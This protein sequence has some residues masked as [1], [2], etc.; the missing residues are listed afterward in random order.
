MEQDF[1]NLALTDRKIDTAATCAKRLE[2]FAR[3]SVLALCSNI[4]RLLTRLGHRDFCARIV[5]SQLL[6]WFLDV[7][8]VD[9][10]KV[11]SKSSSDRFGQ[12][13]S[14]ESL[15]VINQKFNALLAA[16]GADNDSSQ[17]PSA[18]FGLPHTISFDQVFF[19]STCLKA[20]LHFPT[21]WVLLRDAAH[22]LMKATVLI[23]KHGLKNR[24]PQGPLEFLSEMNTLC[25][26]MAAKGR[27][28]NGKK[29]RK[30]VL[31]EMKTLEKCIAFHAQAHL[32][33]LKI[34]RDETEFSEAQAKQIIK[35]MEG[36]L[37]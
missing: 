25:I 7:G 3:Y 33:A 9:S 4:A 22:T 14:A 27:T 16:T 21:E 24:M 34:R 31:C 19:D 18:S 28:V 36:V 37:D 8:E 10:I 23:R 20:N 12:R 1:I 35:H 17:P 30:K 6:Q 29:R 15:R 13:V 26:K 5:D 11:F 32:N 2:A